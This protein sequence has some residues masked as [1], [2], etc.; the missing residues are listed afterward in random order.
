MFFLIGLFS[1][2]A[3]LFLDIN[4]SALAVDRRTQ[5]CITASVAYLKAHEIQPTLESRY[6]VDCQ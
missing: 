6:A 1:L 4:S 2:L 5:E 3:F